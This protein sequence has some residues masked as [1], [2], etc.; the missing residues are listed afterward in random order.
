MYIYICIPKI[1]ADEFSDPHLIK[2]YHYVS[3]VFST[4][5][6]PTGF[7]R[8]RVLRH[9]ASYNVDCHGS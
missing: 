4:S 7:E 3:M 5:A 2:S 6:S 8:F 9:A 1:D